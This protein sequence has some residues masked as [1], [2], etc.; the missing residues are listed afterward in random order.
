VREAGFVSEIV[1]IHLNI[2][3][4]VGN[5]TPMIITR[6]INIS[7]FGKVKRKHSNVK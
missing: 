3:Y 1:M 2:V 7:Y 6:V 5:L 4:I